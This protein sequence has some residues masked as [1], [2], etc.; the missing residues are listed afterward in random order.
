MMRPVLLRPPLARFPSVSA[1]TGS[2]FHSSLRSTMTS[3]RCEGVVGLK[4]LSAIGSDP[5]RHVD[6]RALGERDDRL[7]CIG[8]LAKAA[9]EALHLALGADRIDRGDLDLEEPFDRRLHL[10]LRR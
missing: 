8:A 10:A 3:C 7:L 6:R 5:R 9:A 1:L 4:L 2:P